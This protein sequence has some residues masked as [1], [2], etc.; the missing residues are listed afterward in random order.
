M[1][2][3]TPKF[4]RTAPPTGRDRVLADRRDF[5]AN[6][7]YQEP[8]NG[9]RDSLVHIVDGGFYPYWEESG[10]HLPVSTGR[11]LLALTLQRCSQ[12]VRS[13]GAEHRLSARE[14]PEQLAALLSD[15][16]VAVLEVP[17]LDDQLAPVAE[18]TKQPTGM[19]IEALRAV[20]RRRPTL[21]RRSARA[22]ATCST[23]HRVGNEGGVIGPDLTKVGAIRTARDL[24]E[25]LVVP[26]ATIVSVTKRIR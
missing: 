13:L 24:V 18:S 11:R 20:I 16:R 7:W 23:C 19:R 3:R 21:R 8:A 25:S 9:L 14:T 12:T 2:A 6:T 5:G 22:K 17:Q 4:S 1:T 26:G 15:A 10:E